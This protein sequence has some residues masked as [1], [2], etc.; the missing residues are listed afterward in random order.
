MAA[1]ATGRKH[2]VAHPTGTRRPSRAV[3]ARAAFGHRAQTLDVALGAALAQAAK[4]YGVTLNTLIQGAWALV[5]ARFGNRRQVGFGVTVAGR[6]ADLPGSA[7]IQGLF[8][9]SLP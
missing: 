7:S 9:N 8:I 2:V 4:S 5:L 1:R 6:P 3:H